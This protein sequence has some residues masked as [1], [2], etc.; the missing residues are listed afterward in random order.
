MKGVSG[1]Q[2]EQGVI[3][4]CIVSLIV[5]GAVWLFKLYWSQRTPPAT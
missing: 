3:I 5:G 1:I 2:I 4:G